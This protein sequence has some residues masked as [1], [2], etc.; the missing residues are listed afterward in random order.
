VQALAS[1]ESYIDYL[2]KGKG[3]LTK[4][5]Y[6]TIKD[7]LLPSSKNGTVPAI[8]SHQL[9]KQHF[10]QNQQ[11]D[12][13][14]FM[15]Y[16]TGWVDREM[17]VSLDQPISLF[18]TNG[19]DFSTSENRR[20]FSRDTLPPVIEK[21]GK[22]SL[23]PVNP[24]S[25][26]ME[27]IVCCISCGHTSTTY[28]QFLTLPVPVTWNNVGSKPTLT[29]TQCLEKFTEKEEI[30]WKCEECVKYYKDNERQTA[31]RKQLTIARYPK[32]LCIHLNRL[33]QVG[34]NFRKIETPVHFTT[35][36]NMYPY[37]SHY[38]GTFSLLDIEQL[39]GDNSPP[40]IDSTFKDKS[41][42]YSL[43]AVICHLGDAYGGHYIVFKRLLERE[44]GQFRLSKDWVRI[45]DAQW[46]RV[47]EAQVLNQK[48]FLL[49][50]ERTPS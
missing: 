35:T 36:I 6:K 3:N 10:L 32:V 31:G 47:S 48:A 33:V 13:A 23:F 17:I 43:V 25:G 30:L 21:N 40:K 1:L 24:F 39:L 18:H 29:L 14:E 45:S 8:T 22:R 27:S 37:S 49:F 16:L 2:S 46:D 5:L 12:A 9:I 34:G 20:L 42:N 11:R 19:V 50:Y 26:L 38:K 7:V 41:I 28:S 4:L 15:S 44:N